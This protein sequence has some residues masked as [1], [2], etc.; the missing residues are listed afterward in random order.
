MTD[1]VVSNTNDS[2]ASQ[3]FVHKNGRVPLLTTTNYK[4]WSV[5]IRHIL[6]SVSCWEIVDG[7]ERAP[8]AP[9]NNGSPAAREKH[10]DYKKR[11]STAC[12][13][14]YSSCSIDLQGHI[15]DIWE[16]KTIWETLSK[17]ADES[18]QRGG[19]ILLRRQLQL[20]KYNGEGPVSAY[21]SRILSYRDRLAHTPQ[22][23]SKDEVIAYVLIGLPESWSTIS[24]IIENQPLETQ[25]LDS[26]VNTLNTHERKLATQATQATQ[27]TKAANSTEQSK[28]LMVRHQKR[29]NTRQHGGRSSKP[30]KSQ[31]K[32]SDED[33]DDDDEIECWYC[34]KKGHMEKD[35]RLKKQA[36]RRRKKRQ[37]QEARV[38]LAMES[39]AYVAQK[40]PHI[41]DAVIL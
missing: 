25:T 11:K 1:Q 31:D 17:Q 29:K 21:V 8:P 19:P 22:K 27:A 14:L 5:A 35:C 7:T 18:K 24:T 15:N 28:A 16:P 23:L 2:K 33:E 3:Y 36:D 20:E 34:L 6:D 12:S 30:F 26:V 37:K 39:T 10:A 13:L 4:P 38:S 40:A 9:G 32:D 41:S